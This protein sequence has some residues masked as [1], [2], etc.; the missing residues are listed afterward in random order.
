[1]AQIHISAPNGNVNRCKI[2]V[3]TEGNF[4]APSNST[5]PSK[6]TFVIWKA[7]HLAA[8]ILNTLRVGLPPRTT[9]QTYSAVS[10]LGMNRLIQPSQDWSYSNAQCATGANDNFTMDRGKS[11]HTTTNP[12]KT[13]FQVC[14]WLP[15]PST[16][17]SHLQK[18]WRCSPTHC[19]TVVPLSP[20]KTCSRTLP[21]AFYYGIMRWGL[22]WCTTTLT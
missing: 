12:A 8:F 15:H 6:L 11:T 2:K 3:I 10:R 22:L 21:I 4:H 19:I 16:K 17:L 9:L 13:L 20:R 5:V 14:N 7:G 1:M 18:E